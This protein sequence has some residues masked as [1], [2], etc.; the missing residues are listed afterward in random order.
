MVHLRALAAKIF[1][2]VMLESAKDY[3][4]MALTNPEQDNGEY[5]GT[6]TETH[7]N[8]EEFVQKV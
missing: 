7:T 5:T 3:F 4:N 8:V 6:E 2:K 1:L